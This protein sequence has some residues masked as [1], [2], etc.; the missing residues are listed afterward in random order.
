MDER[1]KTCG[2][3]CK[4]LDAADQ[5]MRYFFERL[6]PAQV[7]TLIQAVL[8]E[9][10]CLQHVEVE[11]CACSSGDQLA[12]LFRV[13]YSPIGDPDAYIVL[14]AQ[15]QSH[16]AKPTEVWFRYGV[17]EECCDRPEVVAEFCAIVNEVLEVLS[18]ND[19]L[20]WSVGGRPHCL[21]Q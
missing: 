21:T 4:Q 1:C 6:S 12:A 16:G 15:G 9:H 18:D 17:P 14:I 11:Q 19:S 2:L 20:L 7:T 5:P 3:I 13:K 10:S 8:H